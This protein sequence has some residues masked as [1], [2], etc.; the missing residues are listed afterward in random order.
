MEVFIRCEIM[1]SATLKGV[2][3]HPHVLD[4]SHK[5][6]ILWCEK[7]MLYAMSRSRKR[8][9]A[10]AVDVGVRYVNDGHAGIPFRLLVL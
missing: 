5:L 6:H 4:F 9:G 7:C 1:S 3:N 8:L 2:C 10:C